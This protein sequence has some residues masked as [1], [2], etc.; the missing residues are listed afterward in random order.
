MPVAVDYDLTIREAEKALRAAQTA[1][2]IRN[3][4]KKYNAALGH[5]T[6]GRL[7]LGRRAAELI[8]RDRDRSYELIATPT[9]RR[10]R[11]TNASTEPRLSRWSPQTSCRRSMSKRR[12]RASPRS[13]S[14]RRR[15]AA[16]KGIV[17]PEDFY[18]DQNR[19]AYE[20]CLA[21]WERNEPIN[22]VT[23]AHE[24]SRREKLDDVGGL[25]YLVAHRRRAG[26]ADRRRAL[27]AHRQARR[28]LPRDD[29]APAR[30]SCRWPT[31]AAPTSM[32]RSRAPRTWSWRCA[33][34]SA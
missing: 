15:S 10:S 2:D 17:Q 1:D 8:K 16:S 13:S 30:R 9:H 24:L 27:R 34:R 28:H 19:W 22:Q 33:S 7:L 31:R 3:A 26:D 20:A 23:L 14:T 6:L 5:R 18:R 25:P 29:H 21:L 12:R 4:W 11:G 32:A